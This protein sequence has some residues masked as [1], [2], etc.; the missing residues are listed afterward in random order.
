MTTNTVEKEK[1]SIDNFMNLPT[2]MRNLNQWILWK[3]EQKR[4]K[5][6]EI[7]RD[8]DTG[9]I[10][11]T[12]VP[13]QPNGYNASATNPKHRLSFDAAVHAYQEGDFSGIGFVLVDTDPF[14]IVDLDDCF[15]DGELTRE[16]KEIVDSLDSYTEVSQ[17]GNGLH[18]VVKANAI[19]SIKKQHIE[20]YSQGRF[21]A[22][23]G[24][25]YDNLTEVKERNT[26]I[27]YIHDMHSNKQDKVNFDSKDI[28]IVSP[29][30]SNDEI[31]RLAENGINSKKFKGLFY[32]NDLNTYYP[33]DRSRADAFIAY[34]LSHYTQ[35]LNQLYELFMESATSQNKVL[36]RNDNYVLN[37]ILRSLRYRYENGKKFYQPK[38]SPAEDF[39]QDV[40]TH[41][42]SEI[43]NPE[44]NIDKFHLTELG[45]AERIWHYNQDKIAYS[46]ERGWL[47]W[48][49]KKWEADALSTIEKI[50]NK[51]LRSIYDE[52]LLESDEKRQKEIY[53]WAKKCESR[54]IRVNSIEDVKPL[55]SVKNSDLDAD[56]NLFNVSNGTLNL[57]TGEL[58]SHHHKDMITRISPVN[59]DPNAKCPRFNQFLEEVI[60]DEDGF[61][62]YEVIRYLQKAI[63]YSLTSLTSE[64]TIFFLTGKGGNGKSKFIET[65]QSV[66]GEYAK[67]TNAD[68]FIKKPFDSGI[69]NDI[70]RLDKARFVAAVESEDGQHLAESLIKQLTG[71]DT[72]TARF[73]RK[74]FFEF[75][76]A[77]KIFFSTNHKPIIKG[78]DDGI[79]R[80]IAV[81]PFRV[82]FDGKNK[83]KDPY[84]SEKLS[85]ELPGI[86]N[87]AIEGYKLWKREGLKKP[88]SIMDESEKYRDDMDILKPFLDECC[89]IDPDEKEAGKVVYYYYNLF[90][91]RNDDFKLTNRKF[92]RELEHRGFEFKP[93]TDNVRFLYGLSV[94]DK[95]KKNLE[96]QDFLEN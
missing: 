19:E 83:P 65:I 95:A 70:A 32:D 90:C 63:G 5:D 17:S 50:T 58:Q 4:N 92:Y 82:T 40:V 94:H 57:N 49:G 25:V 33:D 14:V 60:V 89:I 61:S 62:D 73:L 1:R 36:E 8:P 87:W 96:N 71:G 88:K 79:W 20:M 84:L 93:G 13:K 11:Y 53:Q 12:K 86:L 3:K 59:Y 34:E 28:K 21:F 46:K 2:E 66:L 80:R 56:S 27:T 10:K 47:V 51:T 48:N 41:Y 44:L 31:K 29:K 81:I 52:A 22:M 18:I 55:A 74:E 77:F 7:L 54:K 15:I 16:A 9:F 91:Q 64:Q 43:E 67:Q 69:N 30:M 76:P 35:D 26:A 38:K 39:G 37:T 72:I 85:R 6:G 23:T 42:N 24:E 78:S 68:T 45:N 75:K